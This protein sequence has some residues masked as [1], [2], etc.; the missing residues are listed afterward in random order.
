MLLSPDVEEDLLEFFR[1]LSAD[2][3]LSHHDKLAVLDQRAFYQTDEELVDIVSYLSQLE[4]S[5]RR[6]EG[7]S[8]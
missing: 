2:A 6:Q 7:E 4:P 3:Y 1:N 5:A 8:S